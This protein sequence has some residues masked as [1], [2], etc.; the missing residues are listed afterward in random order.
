MPRVKKEKKD[1]GFAKKR[2][3]GCEANHARHPKSGV[4]WCAR[5]I[6]E[7]RQIPEKLAETI[8]NTAPEIY[9]HDPA[10]AR[11]CNW[12]PHII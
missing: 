7:G 4:P 5:C 1:K 2:Y 12:S 11:L 6:K 10:V 9:A 8:I 3:T